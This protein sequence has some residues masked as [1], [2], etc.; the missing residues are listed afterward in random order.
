MRKLLLTSLCVIFT[1]AVAMSVSAQ[2]NRVGPPGGTIYAH[3]VAYEV[4]ATP[5]TLPDRGNFD[6]LYVFPDCPDCASVS[7]SAPGD[8]NYNGGRWKV[9][10]A[11]GIT[12]QLTNAEDVIAHASEFVDTGRRFSCPLVPA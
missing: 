11:F 8:R 10:Q 9:I 4:I 12:E 1:L 2:D 6:T 7:E 3:N 5:N